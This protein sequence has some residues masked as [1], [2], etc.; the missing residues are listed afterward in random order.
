MLTLYKA[1]VV[2]ILEY[3]CQLWN[4]DK[5]CDVIKLESVQRTFTFRILGMENKSYWERLQTLSLY[6]LQR[7]RERYMIIYVWKICMGLVPNFGRDD[8]KLKLHGMGTRLGKR[9][10][11]PTLVRSR[12]G[13]LREK[14]FMVRGPNLFNSLPSNIREYDGSLEGF[15][16]KVDRFLETIPD[17]PPTPGYHDAACGNSIPRQIAH[18]RAQQL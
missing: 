14:S 1:L 17:R 10:V 13:T 12:V 5:I 16:R 9:C 7:R 18:I 11:L 6:S 3:C 8:L 4:P 2:P 15:K